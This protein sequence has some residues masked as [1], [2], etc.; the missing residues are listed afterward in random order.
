VLPHQ[1]EIVE[2]KEKFLAV[3]GGYGAGKTLPACVLGVLLSLKVAGNVGLVA[4]RSYSKLHDST[5]RIF[6]ETLQRVG[7]QFQTR[8]VRDGWPHRIVLANQSEV[9]FR[10]TKDLGRF[11]GPEYGWFYVDEAGEEPKKTWTDLVG[12]LRLPHAKKYLKGFLTTNPPHQQH[13]IAELFGTTP[14]VSLRGTTAYRLMRVA[15]R[16][17]PYLPGSYIDDLRANN[18]ESEVRRIIDGEYGFSYEGKAVYAPPFDFAKH[19]AELEVLPFSTVRSWDFGYHSPAVLWHQFLQCQRGVTHWRVLHEYKGAD[20]DAE[21]LA[22]VVLE[23]TQTRFPLVPPS[24]V[25]DVGDAAGAQIS[26]KGPGPIIRLQ[27]PPFKFRFKYRHL[28][29]I[30]PGLSL[31][32]GALAAPGCK[33][34]QQVF[35]VDRTCRHL[36]DAMAGGYHYPM[37]KPGRAGEPRMLKP[38][39]DGFYDDL[40]DALRYAGENVYRGLLRDPRAMETLMAGN[41]HERGDVSHDPDRWSWMERVGVGSG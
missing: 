17:N 14:G 20:M 2:S 8:E 38:T 6:L 4:R 23:Q 28:P 3:V 40:A 7:A 32:R 33:C 41:G 13:W 26:D 22:G 10:E 9:H 11:L 18:P 35:T 16:V 36:L 29:N 30:D 5:Q 21:G 15:T 24:A 37:T 31:I 12:R 19:V 34:G 27:R 1:R 25:L 39:K